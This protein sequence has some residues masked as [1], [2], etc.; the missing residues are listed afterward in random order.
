MDGQMMDGEKDI[1]TR[2]NQYNPH[3]T[4]K[5]IYIYMLINQELDVVSNYISNY[6]DF[7]SVM[8]LNYMTKYILSMMK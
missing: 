6:W 4:P 1:W 7:F 3:P 5:F 2:W 8:K